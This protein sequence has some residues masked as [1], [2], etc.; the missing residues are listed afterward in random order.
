MY[1]ANLVE[2]RHKFRHVKVSIYKP[3]GWVGV[4]AWVLTIKTTTKRGIDIERRRMRS[5]VGF[6]RGVP[7]TMWLT[8]A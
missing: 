5:G 3:K 7:Q 4:E 1:F 8:I 2:N 6:R